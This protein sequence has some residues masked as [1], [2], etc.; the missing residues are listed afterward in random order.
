[1]YKCLLMLFKR[2]KKISKKKPGPAATT[3]HKGPMWYRFN[4]CEWPQTFFMRLRVF[5]SFKTQHLHNILTCG[6]NPQHFHFHI[7][8]SKNVFWQEFETCGSSSGTPV[9]NKIVL[10]SSWNSS[11]M[12]LD[13]HIMSGVVKIAFLKIRF[14]SVTKTSGLNKKQRYVHRKKLAHFFILQI[15]RPF[16]T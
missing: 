1:M 2:N 3:W 10:I 11:Y 13:F 5:Y 14:T 15:V 4:V 16:C 12:K 8:W 9:R 7:A 6:E